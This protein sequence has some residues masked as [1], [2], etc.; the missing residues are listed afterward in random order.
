MAYTFQWMTYDVWGN[1]EEGYE[2]NDIFGSSFRFKSEEGLTDEDILN[3]LATIYPGI[4][5]TLVD[6]DGDDVSAYIDY[7]GKPLGEF[8]RRN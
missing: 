1:E 5:T 7:N 4:D 8:R 3:H 2:V 6:I